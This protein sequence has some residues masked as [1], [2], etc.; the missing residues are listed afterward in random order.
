[1]VDGFE[2]E[3]AVG[4]GIDEQDFQLVAKGHQFCAFGDDAALLVNG[5]EGN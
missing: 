1:M 4:L 2:E 3:A 5:L